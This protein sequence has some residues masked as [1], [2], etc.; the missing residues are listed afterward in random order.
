MII[1][2]LKYLPHELE[3]SIEEASIARLTPSYTV[4]FSHRTKGSET[5]Q[6]CVVHLPTYESEDV[7]AR[8][9]ALG[10]VIKIVMLQTSVR[11][12]VLPLDRAALQKSTLGKISRKK[13][14]AA[15]ES[16]GYRTYLELND[17]M[18]NSYKK[19]SATS[20]SKP[21]NDMESFLMIE[22]CEVLGLCEETLHV[23]RLATLL[24]SPSWPAY[25]C[26][27]TSDLKRISLP[28]HVTVEERL[29]ASSSCQSLKSQI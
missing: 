15:F 25:L 24:I 23:Q 5:K 20:G 21:E 3:T 16:G 4:Y 1:N 7:E 8:I 27:E 26:G 9:R 14:R 17:K 6:L 22:V 11:P 13:I 12:Y 28:L 29:K 2:G 19:V 18:V 10:A